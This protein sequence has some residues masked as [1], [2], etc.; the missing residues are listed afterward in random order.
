MS[1]FLPLENE[2]VAFATP[3]E[4]DAF[5]QHEFADQSDNDKEAYGLGEDKQL[6]LIGLG[7]D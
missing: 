3:V 7:L 4:T 1:F 2:M 5:R 6:G